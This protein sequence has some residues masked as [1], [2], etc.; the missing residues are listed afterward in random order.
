MKHEKQILKKCLSKKFQNNYNKYLYTSYCFNVGNTFTDT[1]KYQ[2]IKKI[3]FNGNNK[4]NVHY[5]S[6]LEINII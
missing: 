5:F 3:Y 4:I 2:K 1:K 6:S